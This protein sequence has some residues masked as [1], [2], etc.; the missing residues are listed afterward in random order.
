V[1]HSGRALGVDLG[2]RRIGL[3]LS[4]PSGA[5]ASPVEILE[6]GAE[7]NADLDAIVTRARAAGASVI[8]VGVPRSLSGDLGPAA[9]GALEQIE[10]L[11]ARTDIAI[12]EQDERLSTVEATRK[13]RE[14]GVTGGP[15]DDAAAAVILQAWLDGQG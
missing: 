11:R 3:A 5:L 1:P 12:V 13:R 14:A 4:D 7:P 15:V 9:R 6:R 10:Q 2:E 8:V